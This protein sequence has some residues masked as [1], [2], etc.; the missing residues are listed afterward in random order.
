[1]AKID[2]KSICDEEP[3]GS[4]AD[5]FFADWIDMYGEIVWG[6]NMEYCL[7]ADEEE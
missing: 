2:K 1:M 4:C 7:R 5:C 6:C 3:T